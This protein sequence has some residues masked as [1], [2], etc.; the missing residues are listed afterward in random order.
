MLIKTLIAQASAAVLLLWGF[1]GFAVYASTQ[2]N[3]QQQD[4]L[5]IYFNKAQSSYDS[6]YMENSEMLSRF[7]QILAAGSSEAVESVDV[8]AFASPEG[9]SQ[10]NLELC[11]LRSRALASLLRTRASAPVRDKISA[12]NGGEAWGILR[13]RIVSDT[14][15]GAPARTAILDIIDSPKLYND[16]K[17]ARIKKLA[18]Q[19]ANVGDVYQY[20]V[21]NHYPFLRCLMIT[22][23]FRADNSEQE[24]T[25]EEP[26]LIGQEQEIPAEAVDTLK[27]PVKIEEPAEEK[28]IDNIAIE[29][30]PPVTQQPEVQGEQGLDTKTADT[31][32]PAVEETQTVTDTTFRRPLF[33][34]TNNFAF[35][36]LTPFTGFHTFPLAVGIE[37]PIGKHWSTY[38]EYICTVPWHAWNNNADCVELMHL[39]IGGRW[40][41]GG[42]FT[43]PFRDKGDGRPLDGWYASFSAGVGYYDFERDGKGYQGEEILAALGLGYSIAFNDYLSLNLGIGFGPLFTYYRYYEGRSSN[44]HLMFQYRGNWRYLGVTDANITLTWLLYQARNKRL[45]K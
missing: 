16:A 35:E 15:L 37:V 41:P 26:V 9:K 2:T 12:L 6:S 43:K 21:E 32:L 34:L 38:A 45:D 39:N 11:S 13:S 19:D 27:A 17:E 3:N 44:E 1:G 24:A 14:L 5:W 33:A 40:Y 8:V 29:V 22:V 7:E 28:D 10:S 42:S 36:A 4:T 25:P 31:N 23:N 30:L 18:L 20:L